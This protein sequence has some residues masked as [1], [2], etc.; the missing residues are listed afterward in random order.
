MQHLLPAQRLT[1]EV[2]VQSDATVTTFSIAVLGNET[3]VKPKQSFQ[4]FGVHNSCKQDCEFFILQDT[5]FQL[6][7]TG[8]PWNL[9]PMVPTWE[10]WFHVLKSGSSSNWEPAVAKFQSIHSSVSEPVISKIRIL[11]FQA[12]KA[13]ISILWEPAVPGTGNTRFQDWK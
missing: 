11:Q 6:L 4:P 2:Y 10:N 3:P 12:C 9:Q 8:M 5:S 1:A 7:G 13:L